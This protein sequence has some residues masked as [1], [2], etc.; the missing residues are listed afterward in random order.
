MLTFSDFHFR[1]LFLQILFIS[2]FSFLQI[3]SIP[4]LFLIF[5]F[6]VLFV[7]I[8]PISFFLYSDFL[9]SFPFF[10][11]FLLNQF[12][13]S[14][15]PL[16]TVFH[17]FFK[18]DICVFPKFQNLM[19]KENNILKIRKRRNTPNRKRGEENKR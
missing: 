8:Y 1:F 12:L 17:L 18:M 7:Q 3:S 11:D 5:I 2:F 19:I 16:S 13:F 14:D 4:I 15:F 9:S 10:I 6:P